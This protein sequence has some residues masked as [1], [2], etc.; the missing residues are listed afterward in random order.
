MGCRK[1]LV[2]VIDSMVNLSDENLKNKN[3]SVIKLEEE[4]NEKSKHNNYHGTGVCNYICSECEDV[5]ILSIQVLNNKN[6]SNLQKVIDA[7]EYSINNYVDVI[8]LSL[9]TCVDNEKVHLLKEVCDRAEKKGIIIFSAHNNYGKKSY[10]ASFLNVIGINNDEK[11]KEDFFVVNK[12]ETNIVFSKN[13]ITTNYLGENIYNVGN[14]FLCAYVV[15]IFSSYIKHLNL[16]CKN[17]N[18]REE[19][20]GFMEY[21]N[22]Q[23]KKKI[24]NIFECSTFE[25]KAIVYPLNQSNEKNIHNYMQK[26]N[27]VGYYDDCGDYEKSLYREG[28]CIYKNIDEVVKNCDLFILGHMENKAELEKAKTIVYSLKK[29]SIS[30]FMEYGYINTFNRYV[31]AK[32]TGM[33]I[34]SQHL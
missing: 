18:L 17:V 9:G 29:H 31:F 30:I 34:N 2:A 16:N 1:L 5:E 20:L 21:L 7:I 24:F 25:K 12:K 23:Y 4:S 6:K 28:V 13:L 3:I 11:I 14:S 15:G 10:P 19:F 26:F 27:I 8:N 22:E 32:E 33:S